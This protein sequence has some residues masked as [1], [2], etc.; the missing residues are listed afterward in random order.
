MTHLRDPEAG[1][2]GTP[3]RWYPADSEQRSGETISGGK[4]SSSF[5]RGDLLV[6]AFLYPCGE[7]TTAMEDRRFTQSGSSGEIFAS[8]SVR[9]AV[10]LSMVGGS[11]NTSERRFRDDRTHAGKLLRDRRSVSHAVFPDGVFSVEAECRLG[12]VW[13]R[14]LFFMRSNRN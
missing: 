13:F 10:R 5:S 12:D 8:D 6:P 2:P 1:T 4:R 11:L 3:P 9:A 14:T 7:P